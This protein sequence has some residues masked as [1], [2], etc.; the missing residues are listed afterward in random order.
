MAKSSAPT[1]REITALTAERPHQSD[2]STLSRPTY[3]AGGANSKPSGR[4][5]SPG[6]IASD[7]SSLSQAAVG[8]REAALPTPPYPAATHF[9]VFPDLTMASQTRVVSSAS[10]KVGEAGVPLATPSRKSASWWMKE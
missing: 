5:G 2:R 8:L 9:P 4:L 3:I 1:R 7:A 10:R 6:A